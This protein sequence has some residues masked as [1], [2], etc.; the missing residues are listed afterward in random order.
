MLVNLPAP[1]DP[2]AVEDRHTA[3][4]LSGLHGV[5]TEFANSLIGALALIRELAD[6][7]A[8]CQSSNEVYDMSRSL[9]NDFQMNIRLAAMV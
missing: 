1:A 7:P 6:L 5:S 4:A 3:K 2:Q 9:R 8:C